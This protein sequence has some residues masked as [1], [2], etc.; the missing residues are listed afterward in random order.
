MH[1]TNLLSSCSGFSLTTSISSSS[2]SC[3]ESGL[4]GVAGSSGLWVSLSSDSVWCTDPFADPLVWLPLMLMSELCTQEDQ[5]PSDY[6][7]RTYDEPHDKSWDTEH[8]IQG[9]LQPTFYYKTRQLSIITFK[10]RD[11]NSRMAHQSGSPL[12]AITKASDRRLIAVT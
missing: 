8:A 9:T 1:W 2:G 10:S 7:W 11:Y 6:S 4:D 12:Y 5:T 3:R